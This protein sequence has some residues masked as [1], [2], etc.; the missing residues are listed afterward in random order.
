MR[1]R[2]AGA[3][4]ARTLITARATV[5]SNEKLFTAGKRSHQRRLGP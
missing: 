4:R 3:K 5:V 1:M 2:N